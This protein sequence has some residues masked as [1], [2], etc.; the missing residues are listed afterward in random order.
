[1]AE[2]TTTRRTN[3]KGNDMKTTI[4]TGSEKQIAWATQIRADEMTGVDEVCT[5]YYIGRDLCKRGYVDAQMAELGLATAEDAAAFV[6]KVRSMT[7]DLLDAKTSSKWWIE[8]GVSASLKMRNQVLDTL[9]P[10]IA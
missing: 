9:A 1:M 10:K 5:L 4:L 3:L 8:N 7:I 2:N 6:A